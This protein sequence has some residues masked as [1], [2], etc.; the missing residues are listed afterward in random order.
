MRSNLINALHLLTKWYVFFKFFRNRNDLKKRAI[1]LVGE[2]KGL[3]GKDN[4]YHFFQYCRRHAPERAIYFL[5]SPASRYYEQLAGDKHIVPYGSDQ[6]LLY[7]LAA[8]VVLFSDSPIDVQYRTRFFLKKKFKVFLA[9]GVWSLKKVPSY[10]WKTGTVGKN[11]DLFVVASNWEKT[12]VEQHY[13]FPSDHIAVTGF[14]RYDALNQSKAPKREIILMPT[15]RRSLQDLSPHQLRSSAFFQFYDSFLRS[16]KLQAILQRYNLNLSFIPH[17]HMRSYYRHPSTPKPDSPRIR[18]FTE[19]HNVQTH[20]I[21]GS[22]MITDYSSV[23]FDF[24]YLEKPVLFC[25]I[26]SSP[27]H[28]EEPSRRYL[29]EN[30]LGPVVDDTTDLIR[31]IET[32]R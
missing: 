18:F 32:L 26:P 31:E 28:T 21:E 15:W 25:Y 16:E 11:I 20:L 9:H 8:K 2:R 27:P 5:V 30:A 23:A 4:G 10:H 22:I 6:H 14:S 19:D 13:H 7:L 17:Q 1:W 12:W 3:C 24:A 29:E